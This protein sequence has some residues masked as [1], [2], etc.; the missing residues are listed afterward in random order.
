VEAV[1][2]A[3]T[4][5][6]KWEGGKPVGAEA[7]REKLAGLLAAKRAL[8]GEHQ[9][10]DGEDGDAGGEDSGGVAAVRVAA[11]A[12]EEENEDEI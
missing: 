10:S 5:A 3:I 11:A 1:E 7:L 2:A 9:D 6:E 4:A 8:C 12:A